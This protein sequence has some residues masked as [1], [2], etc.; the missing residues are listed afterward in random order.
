MKWSDD[1]RKTIQDKINEK[2][3]EKKKLLVC[4]V[5]GNNNFSLADG[6]TVDILQETSGGSLSISGSGI[7]EIVVVCNHCGYIMKFSPGVLGL[8][9]PEDGKDNATKQ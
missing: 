5:C 9:L 8:L 1:L 4:S 3:N 7:P 2:L 6:F